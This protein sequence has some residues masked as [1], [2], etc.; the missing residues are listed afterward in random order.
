[1]KLRIYD[2]KNK[3]CGDILLQRKKHTKALSINLHIQLPNTSAIA[4]PAGARAPGLFLRL[5]AG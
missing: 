5:L 1:M 3:V 4:R 2:L